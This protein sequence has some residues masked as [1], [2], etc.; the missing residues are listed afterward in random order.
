[1]LEAQG[2]L[3]SGGHAKQELT[4][5]D[6]ED[7]G[8]LLA[9]LGGRRLVQSVEGAKPRGGILSASGAAS[10]ASAGGGGDGTSTS[11]LPHGPHAHGPPDKK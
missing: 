11:S 4:D 7:E 8:S 5:V 1:M 6:L 9:R 10:L 2:E 3:A